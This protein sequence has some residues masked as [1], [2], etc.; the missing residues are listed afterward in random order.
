MRT[1]GYA[2]TNITLSLVTNAGL[3][4]NFTEGFTITG[5]KGYGD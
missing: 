3:S 2:Y 5:V 1:H 4:S